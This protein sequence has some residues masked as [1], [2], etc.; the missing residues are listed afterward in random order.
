MAA[1]ETV[2][3]IQRPPA[4]LLIE[5]GSMAGTD[6]PI[7]KH[8]IVIGRDEGMV[9]FALEDPLASRRHARLS[10]KA[11]EFIIE[12]LDSSNGTL[13]NGELITKPHLLKASDRIAI[14]QSILL[15]QVGAEAEEKPQPE[16]AVQEP[17]AAPQII[18]KPQLKEQDMIPARL[19][20]T[21]ASQANKRLG[22]ENLGSLSESHGF[23]PTKPL[24]LQLPS[25]YEVWDEMAENLPELFQTL[26]VPT[27]R[28]SPCPTEFSYPG[29]KLPG[30]W[31]GLRHTCRMSI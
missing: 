25:G 20:L 17:V 31:T 11:I 13:L 29:S 30:G 24:S 21:T 22:H 27:L 10:W 3:G 2:I 19:I 7:T 15:F 18:K 1:H 16:P 4:K 12:D 28:R 14:G 8:Q 9:D 6:F 5:E 26:T 23:L